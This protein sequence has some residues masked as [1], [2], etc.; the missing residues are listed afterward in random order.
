M[1]TPSIGIG[2]L[3]ALIQGGMGVAVS[4]TMLEL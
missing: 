1:L 4:S 3:P 2:A